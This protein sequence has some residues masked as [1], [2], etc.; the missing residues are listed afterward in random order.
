MIA[1][2]A[3]YREYGL[4]TSAEKIGVDKLNFCPFCGKKFSSDLYDKYYDVL[5]KLGIDFSDAS[6]D[7]SIFLKSQIPVEFESDEWWPSRGV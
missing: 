6:V 3:K 4:F 1:C 7:D 2:Q 5:A